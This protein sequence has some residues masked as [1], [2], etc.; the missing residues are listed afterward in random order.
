[1]DETQELEDY[2][3]EEEEEVAEEKD[4]GREREP[5]AKLRIFN[6]EHFSET[7]F[8]LFLGENVLGRDPTACNL[9][10]SACSVSKRHAVISLSLLR[11]DSHRDDDVMEALLWDLGSMNGTR[12]GRLR[13]TP[14]VRYALS[15]G[16]SVV[17]AD[18]PC[19]YVC[20]EQGGAGGKMEGPVKTKPQSGRG[21]GRHLSL[22][23]TPT[24]L[25]VT[26]A[27]ES[28]SDSEGEIGGRRKERAKILDSSQDSGP[29]CSTFL[30]PAQKVIPE[31][32]DESSSSEGSRFG[33]TPKHVSDSDPDTEAE[34]EAGSKVS[35]GR[36]R[37]GPLIDSAANKENV[38]PSRTTAPVG[39]PVAN[40]QIH[41][42]D[43]DTDLEAEEEVGN[44]TRSLGPNVGSAAAP[45]PVIHEF[46]LDSDTDVEDNVDGTTASAPVLVPKA[47]PPP[48]APAVQQIDFH[49]DSDTDA[50]DNLE[51]LSGLAPGGSSCTVSPIA[52]SVKPQELHFD[53]DTDTEDTGTRTQPPAAA[54]GMGM[55]I[56]SDSDEDMEE[57]AAWPFAPTP[58]AGSEPAPPAALAATSACSEP[59]SDTDVEEADSV[60]PRPPVKTEVD[61]RD[62]NMDS[63]TDVEDDGGEGTSGY[64]ERP[65]SSTPLG[66][67]LQVEEMETQTF[68]ITSNPFRRPSLPPQLKLKPLHDSQEGSAD[69]DIVIAATQCF[70]SD[71][72][73]SSLAGD[74][75]LD[76]TQLFAPAPALLRT[77]R[78]SLPRRSPSSWG[79]PIA[80]RVPWLLA[81]RSWRQSLSWRPH[82][83]MGR[84]LPLDRTR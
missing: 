81:C 82:K 83:P 74:P 59:D 20:V 58:K 72:P 25:E 56:L 39:S 80:A 52:P 14:H 75:T 36:S 66:S 68:L 55:E 60:E 70:V 26:L 1:M 76:A 10:L 78:I 46:H 23:Q 15:E 22:E 17:V 13:L 2:L 33:K 6:N 5:L 65:A 24:Q 19:Q 79:C 35:Q 28:E 3:I 8:P 45:D 51:D 11:G 50:E 49:L 40:F 27:S 44:L 32:E 42:S 54:V 57:D 62:C 84:P 21:K 38:E 30:S 53:S 29:T 18:L 12:K 9:P 41:D 47:E 77:W 31:S 69:D 4:S 34:G 37:P 16:D 67:A 73:M 43:S 71:G 7:E 64:G 48:A 63:D 61:P